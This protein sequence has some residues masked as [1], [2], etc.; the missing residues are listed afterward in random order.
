MASIR[1]VTQDRL[2]G[3]EVLHAGEAERP[4]PGVA[5]ILVEV[6]AAGVNPVDAMQRQAGTFGAPPPFTVGWDVSGVVAVTGPGVTLYAPGDE[7]FGMLPFPRGAG[8]Y[9]EFVVGPTR[10]F[11]RKPETLS[12]V[13]AAAL[14]LAGLT[15]WQALVDTANVTAG[16]RVLITGASGGVG[17]LALQ[18]ARSRG[19]H[20]IAVASGEHADAV[21]AW[22]A[23]EV[24]DY[25]TTDV[26]TAV[27]D[28]DVA[29]EVI[30]G[31]YPARVLA[32]VRDGGILVSTLPPSLAPLAAAAGERGV[33][34]AGLFVECDQLG[35]RGLAELVTR[36]L[37]RPRIAATYPLEEAASAHARRHGPGK[38]VLTVR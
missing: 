10:A 27:T 28:I 1:V 3:P 6:H 17:H 9:A 18:I 12:H 4:T 35:M 33:R 22:G 25:R 2:G 7:V 36:G 30:G 5:E 37:L 16:T 8:A 19:A 13:E 15:G 29:L 38:V 21:R 24:V 23:D 20:I 32:T 26:A 31:E 11:V 34:L 14:P